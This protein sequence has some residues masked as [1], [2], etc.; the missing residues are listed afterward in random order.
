MSTSERFC[1]DKNVD[2]IP[3]YLFGGLYSILIILI[4]SLWIYHC[5]EKKRQNSERNTNVLGQYKYIDKFI[6]KLK[7]NENQNRDSSI[8]TR[9]HGNPTYS[10]TQGNAPNQMLTSQYGPLNS[11]FNTPLR[12]DQDNENDN[13]ISKIEYLN[14]VGQMYEQ[15]SNNNGGMNHQLFQEN[16]DNSSEAPNNL[17]HSRLTTSQIRSPKQ[18]RYLSNNVGEHTDM[19]DSLIQDNNSTQK[20]YK[21][22]KSDQGRNSRSSTNQL[23]NTMSII[24]NQ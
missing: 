10:H 9:H 16:F 8:H 1:S 6:N 22:K 21:H 13:K 12:N 11:N 24:R 23:I 15:M 18:F 4:L 19:S 14:R 7:S 20:K 2:S 17:D 3:T 5:F